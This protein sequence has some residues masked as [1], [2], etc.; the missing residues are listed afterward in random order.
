MPATLAVDNDVVHKLA[1]YLL[2]DGLQARLA[3]WG[4]AGVLGTARFVVRKRLIAEHGEN[5]HVSAFDTFAHAAEVLEP[6]DEETRFA[7]EL[8]ELASKHVVDLDTGESL[9]TAIVIT[10][11]LE[12]LLT[13]DK[14]AIRALAALSAYTDQLAP[15]LGRVACLEQLML[16][17]LDDLGMEAVRPAVCSVPAA[18]RA[19]SICFSCT[20]A[21]V[22]VES[23]IDGLNSYINDIRSDCQLVL[24][25]VLAM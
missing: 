19:L 6:T 24:T 13:G 25:D 1:R 5:A 11:S 10:R 22:N 18:D 15:I 9:L 17:L 14:R 16:L 7:G 21:A 3:S 2:L 8:E 20:V 23:V 4:G 12:R